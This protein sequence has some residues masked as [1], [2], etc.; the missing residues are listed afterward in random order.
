MVPQASS[1]PVVVVMTGPA[2]YVIMLKAYSVRPECKLPWGYGLKYYSLAY[3]PRSNEYNLAYMG[4]TDWSSA[5]T[6]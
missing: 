3:S 5:F 1:L 4:G 2:L 6:L